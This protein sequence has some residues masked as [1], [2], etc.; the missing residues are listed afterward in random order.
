MEFSLSVPERGDD[1]FGVVQA[2]GGNRLVKPR[3][4]Y[5]S[6]K[7]PRVSHRA[8]AEMVSITFLTNYQAVEEARQRVGGV[9]ECAIQ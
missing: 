5:I 6:A 8:C 7:G 9:V 2:R 1:H 4:N 3:A